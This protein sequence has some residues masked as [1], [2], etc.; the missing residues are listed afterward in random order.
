MGVISITPH[1]VPCP[2]PIDFR[3]LSRDKGWD[4]VT[5]LYY[6]SPRPRPKIPLGYFLKF[7]QNCVRTDSSFPPI[8]PFDSADL[9]S[10]SLGLADLFELSE[11]L[12]ERDDFNVVCVTDFFHASLERLAQTE[13]TPVSKPPHPVRVV[14]PRTG[15]LRP[16]SHDIV[17][18]VCDDRLRLV[19]QGLKNLG[20]ELN[21][22]HFRFIKSK[23]RIPTYLI[24]QI[25]TK[26]CLLRN[27]T[28]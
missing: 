25:I 6:Q 16:K 8:S 1:L 22:V 21:G 10:G 20:I 26:C 2:K 11:P 5:A 17:Q 7:F 19:L 9:G 14:R 23:K 24:H 27:P 4:G 18:P 28:Q 15:S 3:P 12:R 13:K